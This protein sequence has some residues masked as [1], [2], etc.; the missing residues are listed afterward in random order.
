MLKWLVCSA[1]FYFRND[2]AALIRLP[3][4]KKNPCSFANY[5]DHIVKKNYLR[6]A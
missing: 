1:Y 2:F 5:T 3:Q 6:T 4:K